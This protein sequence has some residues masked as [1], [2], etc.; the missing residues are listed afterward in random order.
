MGALQ[1]DPTNLL[2]ALSENDGHKNGMAVLISSYCGDYKS[3]RSKLMK[4]F[5]LE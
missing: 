3:N 1:T 4:G 5:K 2:I